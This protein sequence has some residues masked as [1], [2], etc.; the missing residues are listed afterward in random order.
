MSLMDKDLQKNHEL[1]QV[2]TPSEIALEMAQ[3]CLRLN[4]MPDFIL[5]P[6]C[7]PGTFSEAFHKAGVSNASF[8]CIDVDHRM[9]D[10]TRNINKNLGLKGGV[11]LDNYLKKT[12]LKGKFNI[13][14]MN[15]PYIRQEKI[16]TS[17]KDFYHSYLQSEL[18]E[19]I[20]RRANL[21]SLFLLKGIVDLA[22]GGIMCAIVYDA[23][24]H[25]MYGEKTID[26]IKR[27]AEIIQQ[28]RIKAPF[29]NTLVDAQ[30]LIFRKLK[31][32]LKKTI[33]K[34]KHYNDKL[35]FLSDLLSTRRGTG[36]PSRK[37]F[38]A[39]KEDPYFDSSSAFFVKQSTLSNLLIKPD[40]RAYLLNKVVNKNSEIK[41]W[42]NKKASILNVN[43]KRLEVSGVKG[44]IIF[45][46][47]I[48]G[49]ARHL[50]NPEEIAVSDNFYVSTP[51]ENFPSEAAWLLLNS[52]LY[53]ESI[54]SVARNQGSGL[55]KLQLY[56]YNE[57]RLPDWRNLSTE[58]ITVLV[59]AAKKLISIDATSQEV[60]NVSDKIA[61]DFFYD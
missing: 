55:S 1:G 28:K 47:Y 42:L 30:I 11:K 4:P 41:S 17:D 60:R 18:D 40:K 16:P 45:N 46:Y 33:K 21:F 48:R 57:A 23:I 54:I 29:D 9:T 56:E 15:P 5:D 31:N 26:I 13:V 59:N 27:H 25:T 8:Y 38:L 14:I 7:G 49:A 37:I 20:G 53:L 2:W 44:P 34:S 24:S 32:P 50:W 52:S 6:A 19:K 12:T 43:I 61:K 39:Q 35:V 3:E 22:P 10:T 51:K 36:L 58:Q